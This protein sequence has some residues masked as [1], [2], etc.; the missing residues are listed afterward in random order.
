MNH[1][2]FLSFYFGAKMSCRRS[3]WQLTRSSSS[4]AR[5]DNSCVIIKYAVTCQIKPGIR[6]LT[7]SRGQSNLRA[8]FVLAAKKKAVI[9][10]FR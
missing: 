6:K 5:N 8:V 3:A 1:F 7:T 2:V 9:V 4:I 10:S